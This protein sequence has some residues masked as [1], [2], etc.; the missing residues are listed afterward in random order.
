MQN[1]LSDLPLFVEVAKQRSF[2]RAA[3]I[4]NMPISTLS[5]RITALEKKIK[6]PLL[7]RN[8][9]NVELTPSG[10]DFYD[11]AVFIVGEAKIAF[12]S[13]T[14][15][16]QNPSGVVRISMGGDLFHGFLGEVLSDFAKVW[17]QIKL[18]VSFTDR[19]VDLL[20]E[21]FDL[22]L[23]VGELL[24]SSLIARKLGAV[25][26]NLYATP[27]FIEAQKPIKKV[28]DLK[29][30]PCI[31]LNTK[32]RLNIWNLTNGKQR[33]LVEAQK[34]YSCNTLSAIIT[35]VLAGMGVAPLAPTMAK[36]YVDS[37]KLVNVL[38]GWSSPSLTL[39][40][41]MANNQVPMRV[42]LLVDYL[43]DSVE[44]ATA[45]AEK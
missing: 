3:N 10:K 25:S 6:V 36:Q 24:D 28:G 12:E 32:E 17:P 30:V 13:I 14:Q 40:I 39:Y 11:R 22:D 45:E 33:Q 43:V 23:R 18:D 7:Y 20:K 9:R 19:W 44:K 4:L 16:M 34:Q 15:N 1:I 26:L 21:P 42:R 5:R 31:N 35:F 27:E 29:K 37:G 8:S 38:P 2:T 41:V